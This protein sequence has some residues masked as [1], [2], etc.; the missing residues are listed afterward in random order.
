[1]KKIEKKVRKGVANTKAT[2]KEGSSDKDGP[3]VPS[4]LDWSDST[5]SILTGAR[6]VLSSTLVSVPSTG[7]DVRELVNILIDASGLEICVRDVRQSWSRLVKVLR[8]VLDA[9]QTRSM[10]E[11]DTVTLLLNAF[12]SLV[13]AAHTMRCAT[14]D[15][16]ELY[17]GVAD[18]D[19][20]EFVSQILDC[21]RSLVC[22]TALLDLEFQG[23]WLALTVARLRADLSARRAAKAA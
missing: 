1:M 2:M 5:P 6:S 8:G 17:D 18:E 12:G 22:Q 14:A 19:R 16:F 10:S 23:A 21:V 13:D 11:A 20:N 4:A 9:V 15:I 7:R 3:S